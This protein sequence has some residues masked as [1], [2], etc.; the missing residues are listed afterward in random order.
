MKFLLILLSL[1]G[2]VWAAVLP[3]F[4]TGETGSKQDLFAVGITKF[5]LKNSTGSYVTVYE[6]N[7]GSYLNTVG[8]GTTSLAGTLAGIMP[9][10]GNYTGFRMTYT[11]FKRQV[12]LVI[13]G[14]TY[15]T[16][17]QEIN[18]S[19]SIAM[20]TDSNEYGVVT[21]AIAANEQTWESEFGHTLTVSQGNDVHI[22]WVMKRNG[23]IQYETDGNDNFTWIGESEIV[24]SFLP[25][26][27]SKLVTLELT[28]D[29]GT[30]AN[31][32]SI[33]LNANGEYLG[34]H[35]FRPDNKMINCSNSVSGVITDL[36]NG[37]N[38]FNLVFQDGSQTGDYNITG[39]Y[40]CTNAAFGNLS[41]DTSLTIQ[42]TPDTSG[43]A[44]CTAISY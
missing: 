3:S 4:G 31:T 37:I 39:N 2:L 20:S 21:T 38:S 27:P 34:S 44:N 11:S 25:E 35:C 28:A 24:R 7:S 1:A 13:G 29:V 32:V 6:N 16:V 17:T 14:T 36:G 5:E 15:Y 19:D 18:Q 10:D 30:Y 23:L 43:E 33:L 26:V 22:V 42:G 41:I 12:T 9:P 8:S 40:N